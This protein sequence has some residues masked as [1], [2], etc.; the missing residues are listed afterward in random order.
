MPSINAIGTVEAIMNRQKILIVDDDPVIVKAMSM[1]LE[2]AG[3][4]VV[5]AADG[6]EAI[7]AAR[8]EKPDLILL[9][10]NFP[11]DV[12]MTWDGFKVIAWLQR[13]D[14]AKGTPV[15]V[16][17]GGEAAKYKARAIQAGAIAYLQKPVDNDELLGLVKL[18]LTGSK[19]AA[20]KKN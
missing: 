10:L 3:Y 12:N 8:K 15:I 19:P 13:V 14:E 6:S 1:K 5:S 11:A 20:T 9:D 17:S 2:P 16:V 7:S 18:S 4:E